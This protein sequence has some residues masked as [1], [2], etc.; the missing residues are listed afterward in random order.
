MNGIGVMLVCPDEIW[1]YDFKQDRTLEA[2]N[3]RNGWK[4]KISPLNTSSPVPHGKTG[5]VEKA[6]MP[7]SDE[8]YWTESFF[9]PSPNSRNDWMNGKRN[10]TK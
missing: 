3:S 10:I 9:A 4:H 5:I 2:K 8:N 1:S 7:V 6:S